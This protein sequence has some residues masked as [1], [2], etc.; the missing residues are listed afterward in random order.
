MDVSLPFFI[1]LSVFFF[2]FFVSTTNDLPP[3]H[4]SLASLSLTP[5]AFT[6]SAQQQPALHTG[7]S[8]LLFHSLHCAGLF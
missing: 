1:Y 7:A 4:L 5:A 8:S 3:S 2:F 6:S